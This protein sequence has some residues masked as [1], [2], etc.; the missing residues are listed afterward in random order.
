MM[1]AM[2]MTAMMMMAM[3]TMVMMMMM[4]VMMLPS[5]KHVFL[6]ERTCDRLRSR[7]LILV[8]LVPHKLR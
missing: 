3:M 7:Y 2:M 5:H 8:E 1:M 4:M 6:S